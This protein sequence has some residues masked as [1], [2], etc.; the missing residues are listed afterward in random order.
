MICSEACIHDHIQ[1]QCCW[2]SD[3]FNSDNSSASETWGCILALYRNSHSASD[4]ISRCL[5]Y[6]RRMG[7]WIGGCED[8]SLIASQYPL[9]KSTAAAALIGVTLHGDGVEIT[10][11]CYMLGIVSIWQS[12]SWV[13]GACMYV[14]RNSIKICCELNGCWQPKRQSTGQ[15]PSAF[16][17][18][19]S[20]N[21]RKADHSQWA[22]TNVYSISTH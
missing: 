13:K 8:V 20:I 14:S 3:A 9:L 21:P 10:R 18:K 16:T 7:R 11:K 15:K 2:D 6:S 19:L 4:L 1:P 17:S 22:Y 5:C 12:Q